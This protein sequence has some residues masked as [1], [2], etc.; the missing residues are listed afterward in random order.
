MAGVRDE[1]TVV[2]ADDDWRVAAAL[3]ALLDQEP[4]FRVVA[5]VADGDDA[6]TAAGEHRAA[7]VLTDVRMPAGGPDVVRR[8]IALPHRPVVA[9]LSGQADLA[10]WTGVLAAGASSYLLKGTVAGDLPALLRRCHQEQF[11][12]GV[13][14]SADVLRRLLFP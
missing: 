3:V 11:V 6:V 8:L 2:V 14:G 4:D 5:Q 7:L 9:A 10:T 12:V 1:I 13:P